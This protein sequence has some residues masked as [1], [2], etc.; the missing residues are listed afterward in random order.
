MDMI[1]PGT[2]ILFDNDGTL[3]DSIPAVARATNAALQSHGFPEVSIEEIADGMRYE[4][5]RR[6]ARHSHIADDVLALILSRD[7]YQHL[8]KS[9]ASVRLFNGVK[10]TLIKLHEAGVQ[11]G[12]VSNN[13]QLVIERVLEANG[14][15]DYFMFVIGEDTA[16]EP[17]PAPG[18]IIQ[19]CR[20]FNV[21]PEA[22]IMVGDSLSDSLAASAAG[23]TSVGVSWN[24]H[25][26]TPIESMGFS[27]IIDHPEEL[28]SLVQV[29]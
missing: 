20:F 16:D 29:S 28:L 25:S 2:V 18:G 11:M 3:T 5:V 19:A 13:R 24:H 21:D 17:K 7:F 26:P 15:A 14:I 27:R 1:S 8:E 9:V 6:M 10:S 12:I 4:T 22:C 23:I